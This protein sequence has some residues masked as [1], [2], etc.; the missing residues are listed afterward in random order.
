MVPTITSRLPALID[1]LVT[2][3]TNDATLGAATPPV[4]IFDG[5]VTTGLDPSLKLFVGLSDPDNTGP[6]PAGETTQDWAALGRRSRDEMVTIHFCAEAWSGID[7]IKTQR[8]AAY[9]IVSAVETL[10]QADVTQ[11]G[12]N[13]LF[14][15]PGITNIALMQANTGDGAHVRVAF[16][17]IFKSRI[18]G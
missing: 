3:F 6:E 9:G 2:L 8:T 18:G 15:D 13:V 10:L 14:P 12:G 4:T 11:F 5:P 1:Y 16:D 17:V 7:D